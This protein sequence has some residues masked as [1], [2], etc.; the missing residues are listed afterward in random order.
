VASVRP[1]APGGRG[2]G[3]RTTPGRLN[4]TGLPLASYIF[5]AYELKAYQVEG[6]PTWAK[7]ERYDII[8][9][10]EDSEE[11]GE[12]PVEQ[13]KFLMARLQ[14]LLEERFELKFH[15]EKRMQPVF[16]LVVAR[17]GFKLR[18]AD[19]NAPPPPPPP[20]MPP[21]PPGAAGRGPGSS[22][23][24]MFTNGRLVGNYRNYTMTQLA[25]MLTSQVSR[26]VVDLTGIEGAYTFSL[27]MSMDNGP[28]SNIAIAPGPGGS[29]VPAPML[30]TGASIFTSIQDLGLK[31][32]SAKAETDMFIVDRLQRPVEN[33]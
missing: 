16:N 21:P 2:S 12:K 8:A 6:M 9:K 3:F 29:P 28:M 25:T 30:E 5:S 19:P 10:M 27:E 20:G 14:T 18:P 23:S 32:E 13:R 4:I 15:R 31:L 33:E 22:M 26:Q 1:S 11:H 17:S 7:T 24:M